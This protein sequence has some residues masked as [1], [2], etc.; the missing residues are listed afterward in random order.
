M[1][2]GITLTVSGGAPYGDGMQIQLGGTARAELV[3]GAS[4][5]PEDAELGSIELTELQFESDAPIA[6]ADRPGVYAFLASF[7]HHAATVALNGSPT[8]PVPSMQTAAFEAFGLPAGVQLGAA[9]PLV[10]ALEGRI[11]VAGDFGER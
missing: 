5:D 9:A 11:E 1:L 3:P 4:G 6:A 10:R 7:V 2:G 8:L